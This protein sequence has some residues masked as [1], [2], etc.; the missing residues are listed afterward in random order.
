MGDSQ[1]IPIGFALLHGE[2]EPF[3]VGI[4]AAANQAHHPGQRLGQ[5]GDR[6]LFFGHTGKFGGVGFCKILELRVQ[7]LMHRTVMAGQ[8]D[9]KGSARLGS[10]ALVVQQQ[11]HI[12]QVAGVLPVERRANLSGVQVGE[13]KCRHGD[14]LLEE[15]LGTVIWYVAS[16]RPPR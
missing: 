15:A 8:I 11:P 16:S 2:Q 10:E 3:L 4:Q 5:D 13:G 7:Q 6:D 1:H 14:E 9:Y 12:E